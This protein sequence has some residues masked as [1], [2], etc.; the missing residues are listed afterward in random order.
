MPAGVMQA[1]APYC[2]S[3]GWDFILINTGVDTVCD[4]C[5]DLLVESQGSVAGP[6]DLASALGTDK[7]TYTW[8]AGADEDDVRYRISGAAYVFDDDAATPY[9]VTATAVKSVRLEVRTTLNAIPGPWSAGVQGWSGQSPPTSL[10]VTG[11]SLKVDVAFTADPAA[12]TT[13]MLHNVLAVASVGGLT[14]GE[15]V[16]DGDT[17]TIG[18]TVYRYKDTPAQA[19][20]VDTGANEAAAKVNIVAA[21][22]ASGTEGVEY[23]A[24]TLIHP[25][26][27][28]T[29]FSGDLAVLTAKVAGAA[30][31]AIALAET[32]ANGANII[33]NNAV[34]LG[35]ATT[36]VNATASTLVT[37]V[38]TGVDIVGLEDDV[39]SVQVRTV[40]DSIAGL[41]SSAD[42]GTV[43][44]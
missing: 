3:C 37:G 30:G 33:V 43:L 9:D 42:T 14:I 31:N 27:T 38:V 4:S 6:T 29:A 1:T 16:S 19:Y 39:I 15:D 26:V 41:Y 21:I 13:D 18:S 24:G 44:S 10:V 25:D 20:D 22:N 5:G 8:T 35:D 12:D 17:L 34:F 23:Y 28:A 36:G 40:Q 2:R 32:F 7:V 11:Q